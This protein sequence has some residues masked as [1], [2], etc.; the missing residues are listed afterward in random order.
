LV[1]T[2]EIRYNFAINAKEGNS[3]GQDFWL[4]YYTKPLHTVNKAFKCRWDIKFDE[5]SW[6]LMH[7]YGH[8]KRGWHDYRKLL[9]KV[10]DSNLLYVLFKDSHFVYMY[11]HL[12]KAIKFLM[13]PKSHWIYQNDAVFELPPKAVASSSHTVNNCLTR[14]WWMKGTVVVHYFSL[15]FICILIQFCVYC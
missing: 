14:W 6:H 4:I 3:E 11:A 7:A 9:P 12:V 2:L 13:P 15:A 5:V 8:D 10:G 1:V